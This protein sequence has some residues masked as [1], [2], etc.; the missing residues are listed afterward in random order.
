MKR[1]SLLMNLLFTMLTGV[2]FNTSLLAQKPEIEWANIPADTFT[3]G[4]SKHEFG[5]ES[6]ERQ[7]KV[8]LSAFKMSKYEITVGQF[9]AFVDATGYKTDADKNTGVEGSAIWDGVDYKAVKGVNWKCDEKGNVRPES[10]YNYPVIHVSWYDARAFAEWM[11]GRLPT[12]AQWEYAC[13]ANTKTPFNTGNCLGTDNANYNGSIPISTCKAGEYRGKSMPVDFSTPNA[14]GLYNMHGNVAEW[15]LDWLANY[16]KEY[17]TDPKGP[18]DGKKR[19]IRGGSWFVND[20]DCRS[21]RRAS[22]EPDYRNPMLGF[23][24]VK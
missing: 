3:M 24:I 10:E 23:R 2:F 1:N 9:K 4:S 22:R 6:K 20:V 16:P 17:Q 5:H 7:H 19:I 11:G 21:A 15:C 18:K 8:R 14:W 13:R 12:E